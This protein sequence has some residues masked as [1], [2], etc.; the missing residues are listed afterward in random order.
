MRFNS[1]SGAAAEGGHSTSPRMFSPPLTPPSSHPMTSTW[2]NATA[3]AE[4]ARQP[5]YPLHPSSPPLL[6]LTR[7]MDE[8]DRSSC[9]AGANSG[10]RYFHTSLLKETEQDRAADSFH[11]AWMTTPQSKSTGELAPNGTDDRRNPSTTLWHRSSGAVQPI[12]N[13]DREAAN[14][15]DIDCSDVECNCNGGRLLRDEGS[16]ADNLHHVPAVRLTTEEEQAARLRAYNEMVAG[17]AVGSDAGG[18]GGGGDGVIAANSRD[19]VSDTLHTILPNGVAR[20]F[21]SSVNAVVHTSSSMVPDG[22]K[23]AASTLSNT[24]GVGA[25]QVGDAIDR[26]PDLVVNAI[27]SA[28]MSDCVK[29]LFTDFSN[30]FRSFFRTN[31]LSTPFV[32]RQAGLI[33]GIVLLSFVAITSEYATEAYFG[34][35]NQMKNAHKVVPCGEVPLIIWGKWY[36]LINF[37]YGV[38]HLVGLTAFSSSNAVVL[39]G[40][41]GMKGSSAQALG[42]ILPSLIVLPLVLMATARSQQPLAIMSNTH[43]LNSVILMCVDFTY[44]SRPPM[45]LW[46]YSP[47]EFFVALGVTVYALTGIGST[48]TVERVMAPQRYLK[49]LRVSVPISWAP[50][51]AFGLSGFIAYGNHTCSVMT[52][53]LKSGPLRTAASA[54]LFFASLT[55]ISLCELSDR[56]L[57]GITRLTHYW[58]ITPNLLSHTSL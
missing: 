35:K 14:C 38:I 32:F 11:H 28:V 43:V 40:A 27:P 29:Q 2:P 23:S 36:P 52:V 3:A 41:M 34:A 16:G 21:S 48:V 7:A 9:A 50:L 31:I 25:Q 1:N 44:K 58:D 33:G 30:T 51:M 42:L 57:L 56:R 49:L 13:R 12:S 10:Q 6:D 4:Q 39:L 55:I 45:K 20:W 37:F 5:H 17:A 18:G 15:S 53:S 22:V 19:F 8:T 24:V 26:L 54:L 47:S 46:S